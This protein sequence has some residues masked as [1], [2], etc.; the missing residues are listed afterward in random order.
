MVIKREVA[1]IGDRLLIE[2]QLVGVNGRVR[3]MSYEMD[4]AEKLHFASRAEAEGALRALS[5]QT[6]AA[7]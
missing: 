2:V 7:R 6:L 1:R 3:S 4:G 5:A